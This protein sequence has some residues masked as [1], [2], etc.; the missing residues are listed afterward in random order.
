M[1]TKKKR[2]CT[3]ANKEAIIW[4]LLEVA[5]SIAVSRL[6]KDDHRG[7]AM[8]LIDALVEVN[9]QYIKAMSKKRKR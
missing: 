9:D 1:K 6:G 7:P 8:M 3:K 5:G 2:K 4:D